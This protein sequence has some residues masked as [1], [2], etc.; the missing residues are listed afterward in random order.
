MISPNYPGSVSALI[1]KYV[2]V[3]GTEE[4]TGVD[5]AGKVSTGAESESVVRRRREFN[6][7]RLVQITGVLQ[8]CLPVADW[9]QNRSRQLLENAFDE[10]MICSK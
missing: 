9:I 4:D 6:T 5:G 2:R 3:V 10:G 7:R 1:F 8:H